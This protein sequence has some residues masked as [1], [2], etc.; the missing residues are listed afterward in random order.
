MQTQSVDSYL[1]QQILS[2]SPLELI[3]L[4]Y[5]AAMQAVREAR[6]HL[7]EKRIKE[8]SRSISRAHSVLAHLYS[9]LDFKAG[10]GSL[11]RQL[12]LLYDYMMRCLL[13][14]NAQQTDKPLEEVLNL[15]TPLAG[16]V[17]PNL[18]RNS[19]SFAARYSCPVLR[20]SNLRRSRRK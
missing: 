2:A 16:R 15:L 6:R 5:N 12:G 9:S 1:E 14:A 10:D 7:A 19:R 4:S 18:N 11:P 3:R 20:G 8:R 13:E 17:E